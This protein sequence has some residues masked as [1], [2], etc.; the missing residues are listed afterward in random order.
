MKKDPICHMTIEEKEAVLYEYDGHPYYF[1]SEGCREKFIQTHHDRRHRSAYELIIIGGGPA[2]L[3]AAVYAATMK[4]DTFLIAGD[5]GGQAT[6]STR[7]KNYMGY[8]FITGPELIKKFKNQFV[9]SNYVDHLITHAERVERKNTVFSV[10]SAELK[11]YSATAIIVCTG[12]RRRKLDIPGE[13]RYQKKGVF[14]GNLQDYSFVQGKDVAVI[15]GGNSALQTAE[16]L[17][18][19]AGIVHVI[20]DYELTADHTVI[21]RVTGYRNVRVYENSTVEQFAGGSAV[22][23]VV[24]RRRAEDKRTTIPVTGMFIS[25]GMEPNSGLVASLVDINQSGEIRIGPGC[26]TSCPGLFAAGDVTDAFGKRIIIASGEGA[27]A[28]L[29]ARGYILDLRKRR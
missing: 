21:E 29:S 16:N 28:A 3:T 24:I 20:S 12:M 26:S 13:E 9:H 5:L 2:G 27:K 11:T 1:C 10:T 23:N 4:I 25:I 19:V 8:D 14:Y 7:I 22:E 17:H 15:G 18:S 6:D